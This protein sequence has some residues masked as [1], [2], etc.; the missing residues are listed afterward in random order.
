MRSFPVTKS[1]EEYVKEAHNVMSKCLEVAV[2][3]GLGVE[4]CRDAFGPVP[5]KYWAHGFCLL[6]G[7]QS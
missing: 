5:V 1:V 2:V 6:F 7:H 3:C 4:R